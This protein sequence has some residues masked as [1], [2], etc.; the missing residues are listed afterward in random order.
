MTGNSPLDLLLLAA[1]A[2]LAA[3]WW[4]GAGV[5]ELAVGHARR[6]CAA[7]GVQFL[8]QSVALSGVRLARDASGAKTL[9]RDYAFEFTDRGEHRDRGTVSMN[10]RR[11]VRVHFPWVRDEAGNR[12]WLQ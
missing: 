12:V 2:A 3:L 11:L 4:S 9:R 1:L 8:D 6:A 10:G 7:R 5:R